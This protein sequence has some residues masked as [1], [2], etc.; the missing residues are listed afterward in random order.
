MGTGWKWTRIRELLKSYNNIMNNRERAS[1]YLGRIEKRDYVTQYGNLEIKEVGRGGDSIASELKEG[2]LIDVGDIVI[3]TKTKEGEMKEISFKEKVLPPSYRLAFS[4]VGGK[5]SFECYHK[6]KVIVYS[7]LSEAGNQLTLLHEVGHAFNNED[8]NGMDRKV[9]EQKGFLSALENA[10]RGERRILSKDE[11]EK[12]KVLLEQSSFVE[13]EA[14]K[15]ALQKFKKLREEGVGLEPELKKLK[16]VKQVIGCSL[17]SG[18]RVY[19]SLIK[20][21]FGK[22][23]FWRKKE[24]EWLEEFERGPFPEL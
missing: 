7:N 23:L 5:G 15:W 11:I 9:A 16:E 13:R 19:M 3:S 12:A 24:R 4:E 20:L 17:K 2:S 18:D 10:A 14:W 21:I 22:P 8:H 1:E 6:G